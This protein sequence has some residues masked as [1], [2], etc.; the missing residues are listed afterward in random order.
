MKQAAAEPTVEAVTPK[1]KPEPAKEEVAAVVETPAVSEQE[2]VQQDDTV[3][4][5]QPEASQEN[6]GNA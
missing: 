2:T 6:E 1:K 3:E 4:A 5:A